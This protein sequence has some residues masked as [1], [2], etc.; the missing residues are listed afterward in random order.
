[1]FVLTAA[2][3]VQALVNQPLKVRLGDWDAA[4]ESEP[5]R[6]QEYSVSRI[7]IHPSFNS[8]NLKNDVAIL[9]LA[10]P[11]QLGTTP[12]ITTACLPA[13]VFTGSRFVWSN[14]FFFIEIQFKIEISDVGS[15]VG[16]KMILM[17]EPSRQFKKKSTSQLN[18]QPN[19][20]HH[21]L[22]HVWELHSFLIQLVLFVLVVKLERTLAP[23]MVARH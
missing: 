14:H 11:V 8:G 15:L 3:R 18:H 6:P 16:V 5:I 2:H 10:T 12:T 17:L 4:S 19:V 7:I 20:N 9:K 13:T 22:Q 1:M 23:V 21:W